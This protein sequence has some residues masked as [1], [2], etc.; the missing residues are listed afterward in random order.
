MT[1]IALSHQMLLLWGQYSPNCLKNS[2]IARFIMKCIQLLVLVFLISSLS[3]ARFDMLS[4]DFAQPDGSSLALY[5]SGDE[6]THRMHDAEGYTVLTDPNTGYAVYALEQGNRAVPSQYRV[7][8]GNPAALGIKKHLLPEPDLGERLARLKAEAPEN[9]FR[10][11]TTGT[12]NNIVIFIRFLEQSE[13]TTPVS[14]YDTMCNSTSQESMR[15]YFLEDSNNQLTVNAGFCPAPVGGIVRSFQDGHNRAYFSPY[16]AITNPIGYD[17]LAEGRARMHSMFRTAVNTV[18]SSGTAGINVDGDNDGFVDN[19]IFVM[20]GDPDPQWA[21]MLWP[22]QWYLEYLP[23]IYETVYI[24]NKIVS[25]YNIQ[26]SN[27]LVDP[28]SLT[29]QG[30]GVLCHEFSHSI[31]FPDLYHYSQDDLDPVGPWELMGSQGVIPQPHFAFQKQKYGG[32]TGSITTITPGANP[33]SYTLQSINDNPFAAYRISSN[34]PNQFYILEYRQQSGAYGSSMP[35]SGLI[36]YR[37]TQ[38]YQMGTLQFPI[39]GNSDGPPDEI[40][41]YRPYG[42]LDVDGYLGLAGLSQAQG[43]GS[44]HNYSPATP[45]LYSISGQSFQEGNLK[46]TDITENGDGTISFVVH[47][48]G[49]NVWTG[50]TDNNW[51]I[52]SNWSLGTVPTA[53][54][55]V[56][57]A[58]TGH[59]YY[60]VVHQ[61]AYASHITVHNGTG[62]SVGPAELHIT[63]DLV[64]YGMLGTASQDAVCFID[65]DLDFGA[66]SSS[67]FAWGGHIY[68]KGDL[69]FLGGSAVDMDDGI[70][71]FYSTGNS[72]ITVK[73]P[74]VIHHLRSSKPFPN[75]V[76]YSNQ[77][78][79]DLSVG[80]NLYVD[81]NSSFTQAYPGDLKLYG[82]L[83]A[84]GTGLFTMTQGTLRLMGNQ[85]SNISIPSGSAYLNNLVMSKTNPGAVTLLS[86][87][88]VNGNLQLLG[89][90][91][92]NQQYNLKL[93]GNYL[94]SLGEAGFDPGIGTFTLIGNAIQTLDSEHFY[95]LE[96]NKSGSYWSVPAGKVIVADYYNWTAGAYRVSGGSFSCSFL[97]D[98]G[99]F[100]N[101]TLS[102][103]LIDYHQSSSAFVDLRGNLTIS[104][105]VFNISGGSGIVYLAYIDA[106]SLTMSGGI[107]D[108]KSQ[109]ILVPDMFNFTENI[110]GG[111]IRTVGS[112]IVERIDFV[113]TGNTLEFYGS[114]DSVLDLMPGSSLHH[115]I[116]NKTSSRDTDAPEFER[117]RDGN[118]T[119]ITRSNTLSCA[120]DLEING[121]LTINNGIFDVNGKNINIA[122]NFNVPSLLKMTAGG[123]LNIGNNVSWNGS[124]NVNSGSISCGGSWSFGPSSTAVLTGSSTL[125]Y[126]P[127]GSTITNSSQQAAFGDLSING[128]GEGPVFNYNTTTGSI[129]RVNGALRVYGDNTLNLGANSSNTASC[130]IYSQG[131]I[132]Q[133]Q[134]STLEIAGYLDLSGCLDLGAGYLASHGIFSFP[135]GGMLIIN[136][137]YFYND[138][139]WIE[140]GNYHLRGGMDIVDGNFEITGNSVYIYNHPTRIFNNAYLKF[141]R[142]FNALEA[143]AF[144]PL[145]G[146]VYLSGQYAC[147]LGITGGNYLRD[148]VINKDDPYT[149]IDLSYPTEIK[150]S[151]SLMSGY[152]EGGAQ[153]HTIIGGASISS[154]FHLGAG[155]ILSM[156]AASTLNVNN[157]GYLY[158]DGSAMAPLVVTR[159]GSSGYYAFGVSSGG[160][161]AAEYTSFEYLNSSGLYLRPGSILD[162]GHSLT[163]CSFANGIPG[164]VLLLVD[165]SQTITISGAAFPANS[166]GSAYNVGKMANTGSL[167]FIGYSGAYAGSAYE[168]DSYNRITWDLNGIYP[169]TFLTLYQSSDTGELILLWEYAGEYDNFKVYVS[170]SP[171]GSYSLLGTTTD[172]QYVVPANLTKAFFKVVVVD[173]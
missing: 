5:V 173:D 156:G 132:N 78:T 51:N 140:R 47:G 145:S 110:T 35:G 18:G 169:I 102:S 81:D 153:S 29:P 46:I 73:S 19:V 104:G 17:G 70:I 154:L 111:T 167:N 39:E 95:R 105:G 63:N 41:V 163:N 106:A 7:G 50:N 164:G 92:H 2:V 97:D 11:S 28:I 152:L 72:L 135:A 53:N 171:E 144:Q 82:S 151:L 149:Q 121:H 42:A 87:L 49:L 136:G 139:P 37:V 23:G 90:V 89:G 116:C 1:V 143:G 150:G 118:Q 99:I 146:T 108:V 88:K 119:R 48:S 86:N 58:P 74:A 26:L 33:T 137:G 57:I 77:S 134:G 83:L 113:P 54:E 71:E 64:S 158:L 27:S 6:Y 160:T 3:A 44:I 79:A 109:G 32:W 24:N 21:S 126:A 101:I 65:G 15:G 85:A 10:A 94:N 16:N 76:A 56:D 129:L 60:P 138:S 155:S 20:Q 157:G 62:L 148:L 114:A 100:G 12:I 66:G 120:R 68:L 162:P 127:Q 34:L 117:D 52:S 13:Y 122:G 84:Y 166:W 170:D 98:P 172:N 93:A 142:S 38:Y 147:S 69:S 67:S 9:S 59:N 133:Q 36:V 40:Y 159:A 107:L 168:L 31:G 91:F 103:G 22:Q 125:L 8:S 25:T 115:V 55:W 124:A 30:M 131:R 141:G 130:I 161:L 80:G 165:N 75:G 14:V 112:L 4:I 96:L 61:D 123:S 45:W 43:R 128:L